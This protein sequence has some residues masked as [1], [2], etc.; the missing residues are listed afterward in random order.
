MKSA[1]IRTETLLHRVFH[2]PPPILNA[3]SDKVFKL[4]AEFSTFP[5]M[6]VLTTPVSNQGV[7]RGRGDK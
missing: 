6:A 4:S 5:Q 3:V 2:R 7:M 1:L